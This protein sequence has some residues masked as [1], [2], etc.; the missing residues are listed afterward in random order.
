MVWLEPDVIIT[1]P[2]CTVLLSIPCTVYFTKGSSSKR[3]FSFACRVLSV[4]NA[5]CFCKFIT[6]SSGKIWRLKILWH[7]D[8]DC[9]LPLHKLCLLPTPNCLSSCLQK[10]ITLKQV[11]K[12]P[13][14]PVP[15]EDFREFSQL[16]LQKDL[17]WCGV[18]PVTQYFSGNTKDVVPRRQNGRG[19]FQSKWKLY[20]RYHSVLVGPS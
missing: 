12:H 8:D 13:S 1:E 11:A 3:L 5:A 2:I 6:C 10:M 15:S 14:S 19:L 16:A 17:S 9:S 18:N 4:W 20:N 7:S